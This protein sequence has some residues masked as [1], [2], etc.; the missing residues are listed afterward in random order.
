MVKEYQS[1]HANAQYTSTYQASEGGGYYCKAIYTAKDQFKGGEL[2]SPTITLTVID[3]TINPL[4]S[5]VGVGKR[6]TLTCK[7]GQADFTAKWSWFKDDAEI[8]A[9][10]ADIKAKQE[11]ILIYTLDGSKQSGGE[12]FCRAEYDTQ[13]GLQAGSID[14]TKATV[15]IAD[16]TVKSVVVEKGK[17]ALIKCDITGAAQDPEVM[18]FTM[19]GADITQEEALGNFQDGAKSMSVQIP[20]I[21]SDKTYSCEVGWNSLNYNYPL[22]V[23]M[24][25]LKTE[26]EVNGVLGQTTTLTCTISDTQSAPNSK[27]WIFNSNENIMSETADYLPTVVTDGTT[28]TSTL[29]IKSVSVGGDF[30]CIFVYQTDGVDLEVSASTTLKV[31]NIEIKGGGALQNH[32]G[33]S[34]VTCKL[35]TADTEPTRV[36]WKY[37]S[38]EITENVT[39]TGFIAGSK[40]TELRYWGVDSDSDFFC[41]WVWDGE[42]EVVMRVPVEVGELE[43]SGLVLKQGET[44][45][46]TC[47][48]KD[49][50]TR[51]QKVT[52]KKDGNALNSIVIGT[53]NKE[54]SW[55]HSITNAGVDQAGEYS[56]SLNV[57]ND[58]LEL[59]NHVTVGAPVISS[60]PFVEQGG[61]LVLTCKLTVYNLQAK[62]K[63]YWTANGNTITEP[64]DTEVT[65]NTV[66]STVT[67]SKVNKDNEVAH[68]CVFV[69]TDPQ[70]ADISSDPLTPD[71]L[72]FGVEPV[73]QYGSVGSV[74]TFTCTGEAGNSDAGN[75]TVNWYST[76]GVQIGEVGSTI[77]KLEI[78]LTGTVVECRVTWANTNVILKTTVAAIVSNVEAL[79]TQYTTEGNSSVDLTCLYK[80]T[81]ENYGAAPSEVGWFRIESDNSPTDLSTIA[82]YSV[83][84]GIYSAGAQTSTLTISN[85][86]I[87]NNDDKTFQCNFTVAG[88]TVSG[89]IKLRVLGIYLNVATESITK[90]SGEYLSLTA[91]TTR[92]YDVSP[93]WR[94]FRDKEQGTT[95][96]AGDGLIFPSIR[97]T[98]AGKYVINAHFEV[99]VGD[100]M[101]SLDVTATTTVIVN[102]GC[103]TGSLKN[104]K[105]SGDIPQYVLNGWSATIHCSDNYM[106]DN[107]KYE[108]SQI[109]SCTSSDFVELTMISCIAGCWY[110]V[111]DHETVVSFGN[112]VRTPGGPYPLYPSDSFITSCDTDNNK[113]FPSG[114]NPNYTCPDGGGVMSYTLCT[115]GCRYVEDNKINLTFPDK[116]VH[117][118]LLPRGEKLKYECL[119][120]E[121]NVYN[122]DH[123]F[124]CV[125]DANNNS[126]SINLQIC[127][128][129][130]PWDAII[131][132]LAV[133][134]LILALAMMVF[135]LY[136][137]MKRQKRKIKLLNG[138][139]G[140]YSNPAAKESDGGQGD[141]E[142]VELCKPIEISQYHAKYKQLMVDDCYAL[143]LE[144]AK[145]AKDVPISMYPITVAKQPMY[146]AKNRFIDILPYDGTR[147][148]L[149]QIGEDPTSHYIN[150]SYIDT[151]EEPRKF[152]AAQG[153][154][155]E[156][157]AD[158]WRMMWEQNSHVIIMVT[159]LVEKGRKKCEEYWS[160]TKPQSYGNTTVECLGIVS[161]PDYKVRKLSVTQGSGKS[162]IVT[163]YHY[164]GWP[165]HGVPDTPTSMIAFAKRAFSDNLQG[166]GPICVHCSAG[167]GRTGT[168]I[169]L[170]L[171]MENVKNN[172]KINIYD[173][174]VQLRKCRKIMVQTESQ[175]VFVYQAV[176]ELLRCGDTEIYAQMLSHAYRDLR[177]TVSGTDKT[178]IQVEYQRLVY[179]AKE[180]SN[181]KF[182]EATKEY[183]HNKNRYHNILPYEKNRVKLAYQTG[184]PGSDYINASYISSYHEKNVY[185]STQAPKDGTVVDFWK[186]IYET[187]ACS[188][189]CMTNVV[190]EGKIKCAQYWPL[191]EQEEVEY[192]SCKIK[193][194]AVDEGPDITRRELCVTHSSD[195]YKAL[196]LVRLWH[197]TTLT[198]KSMKLG[199]LAMIGAIENMA[200]W[201]KQQGNKPA[202]V[203]CGGGVGR[204]AAFIA[205]A[206]CLEQ[207]KLEGTVD[208][209][210]TA[211]Q[212][213]RSRPFM[214]QSVDQYDYIYRALVQYVD[215]FD[216][217]ENFK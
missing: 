71:V 32:P 55:T 185:I 86:K 56:C 145:I 208:I 216:N 188:I 21:Q 31:T 199:G 106:L 14:S 80:A 17:P 122:A 103:K 124:T 178:G 187:G 77:Y 29:T 93:T 129:P 146:K 111:Q 74:A 140:I 91:A 167:V 81:S 170:H 54:S 88:Q 130:V 119:E 136:L 210:Q 38:N 190:E 211:L 168:I 110:V 98:D 76:E 19:D 150:A 45:Q 121:D 50:E 169:S 197:F 200:R 47:S 26:P 196:R 162:R 100:E 24:I 179:I 158:F 142:M 64:L 105:N 134:L 186:M 212:L 107:Y 44:G 209:F 108:T 125:V 113:T 82:G 48:I 95:L 115:D 155:P 10:T 37:N 94:W 205:I 13:T 43:V 172:N 174:V 59:S 148:T 69:F 116:M 203:H 217:Y 163:H 84:K 101:R 139:D 23:D 49:F 144:Y 143:S 207:L 191:Q 189:V 215:S 165:D 157:L 132:G 70:S 90:M 18:R 65:D 213:R 66:T 83:D 1:D 7:L 30:T 166:Q 152:I 176:N 137:Y 2:K 40:T 20:D 192:G 27:Y 89:K 9:T 120:G 153:P 34:T 33:I 202:V 173:T 3:Y 198:E 175:Y 160:D 133:F 114:T 57:G 63:A 87:A 36:Y 35:V 12:Y 52:W 5:D 204:A 131:I 181:G 4:S 193:L 154:K 127:T 156:T 206:N 51:P 118:D 61:D 16:V 183:N 8:T 149:Q 126:I 11:N 39:S 123:T 46:I 79:P 138:G 135:G 141:M 85:V 159:N 15:T 97:V 194:L 60:T 25:E 75:P 182:I 53:N 177:K 147:V 92:T 117:K 164:E 104:V 109:L 72:V 151:L 201:Q 58:V 195:G 184:V 42:P 68:V 78:P 62:P 99:P 67:L 161:F 128:V 112:S 41:N 28:L 73:S 6:Y 96:F 171:Q 214:V 22:T 102:P 180:D